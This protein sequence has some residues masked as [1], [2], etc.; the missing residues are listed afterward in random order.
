MVFWTEYYLYLKDEETESGNF[1][2]AQWL[3]QEL[4]LNLWLCIS[5]NYFGNK[6]EQLKSA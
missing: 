6:W 4:N 5:H 1:L 3:G 2:A